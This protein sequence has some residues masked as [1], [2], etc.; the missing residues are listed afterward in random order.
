MWFTAVGGGHAIGKVLAYS[1]GDGRKR[2]GGMP[3]VALA[4]WTDT[5]PRDSPRVVRR[6]SRK[7]TG[8]SGWQGN[9]AHSGEG[10]R[11]LGFPWPALRKM[12]GQAAGRAGEPSGNGEEPP[13]DGLGG[14]H[15]LAQ[16]DARRPAS[17]VVGHDLDGQPGRRLQG[18][19]AAKRPEGR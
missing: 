14:N 19:L 7:P 13:S 16:T 17:Q 10:P 3:E 1:G 11:E 18:D 2:P 8:P 15:R 5:T 6:E 9:G 12:Q 4:S